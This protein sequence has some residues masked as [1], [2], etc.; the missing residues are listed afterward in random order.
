MTE[1]HGYALPPDRAMTGRLAST[2]TWMTAR[3]DHLSLAAMDNDH[4]LNVL[5]Y[6]VRHGRTL[7]AYAHAGKDVPADGAV[8]KWLVARPVWVAMVA[9]LRSR[10]VIDPRE[11]VFVTLRV[12][13]AEYR[14][15][16]VGN[17]SAELDEQERLFSAR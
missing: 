8:V 5:G 12:R 11:D 3:G 7:W 13:A 2:D 10:G 17:Y 14:Q 15:A 9:Q 16:A 1:F 4:L 6:L